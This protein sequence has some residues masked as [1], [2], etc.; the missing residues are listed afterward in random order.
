MLSDL[1][2]QIIDDGIARY[3]KQT[4]NSALFQSCMSILS[5]NARCPGLNLLSANTLKKRLDAFGER[6]AYSLRHGREQMLQKFVMKPGSVDV[7]TICLI[8]KLIIQE[9]T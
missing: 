3:L 5:R 7:E 9:W 1:H 4:K 8:S 6:A 2:E